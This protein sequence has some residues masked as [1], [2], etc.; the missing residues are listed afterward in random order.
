MWFN[1][2]T[3][4]AKFSSQKGHSL[5]SYFAFI[6]LSKPLLGAKFLLHITQSESAVSYLFFVTM[7]IF[8]YI[9]SGQ[10]FLIPSS[11]LDFLFLISL[12]SLCFSWCWWRWGFSLRASPHIFQL[13][14]FKLRCPVFMWIINLLSPANCYVLDTGPE[15]LVHELSWRAWLGLFCKC[16]DFHIGSKYIWDLDA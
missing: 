6:C 7:A 2:S 15:F 3:L 11:S 8:F 16:I 12:Q 1:N 5:L 14:G 10:S 13:H 4:L 9:K